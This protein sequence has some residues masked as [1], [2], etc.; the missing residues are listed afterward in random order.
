MTPEWASNITSIPAANIRRLANEFGTAAQIG[1]TI[2]IEG[3]T[4]PYRPVA[5]NIYRGS[6]AHKHGVLTALSVQILNML[7][8][9]FYRPGGHRGMNLIGPEGRWQPSQEDGLIVPPDQIG[10]GV[11]YYRFDVKAPE[12]MGLCELFPVSTNRS[13][14]YQMSSLD[15]H[16]V[17]LPYRPEVLI[18]CRRNHFLSDVNKTVAVQ[19]YQNYKF[20]VVFATH[21][22]ECAEFA[23]VVFPDAHY[24]EKLELF[25]NNFTVSIAMNT[26][27]AYWG[28][29]QPVVEPPP[30]VKP[31]SETLL[32]IAERMG[33]LDDVYRVLNAVLHLKEPHQLGTKQ[34]YHIA[35][36][37][38]RYAKSQFG[39]DK[40]LDWFKK[41]G[42][43]SVKRTLDERYPVEMLGVRFPLYFENI[44]RAGAEVRAVTRE[45][46]M[47]WWDT[48]D[49]L[50]L[51][52]WKPCPSFREKPGDGLWAVNYRL[53]T[54]YQS[55]SAQNPW[56]QVVAQVNPY[57]Q[58][59]LINTATARQLGIADGDSVEV[60]SHSGR[61]E[62]VVK[63]TELIHPEVIGISGHF[64]AWAKGKPIATQGKGANFNQL[65]ALDW[66]HID[67]VSSGVD[68]CV[69]VQVRTV[70]AKARR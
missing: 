23:D 18:V 67:P 33:F 37:Y 1:S 66:E 65:L 32:Q 56:L 39:P 59:F 46:G 31:W 57:A 53:P 60:Q 62:G 68:S 64:G 34:Q 3:R 69:R 63:V 41:N 51:P 48:S 15:P 13:P 29:R 30:G 54:H 52:V 9:C 27:H 35:D 40:G 14:M 47:E 2:T 5:V 44:Q 70:A 8:G 24:L 49:Y 11:N 17:H 19:A 20:V 50:A 36:I 12:T 38:D 26:N 4:F 61:V 22:D 43:H 58:K 6:G 10:H 21:L 7:V 42:Y 28:V 45:L 16:R 25:P 55:V